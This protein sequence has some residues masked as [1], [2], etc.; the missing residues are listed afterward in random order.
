VKERRGGKKKAKAKQKKEMKKQLAEDPNYQPEET[1]RPKDELVGAIAK[2]NGMTA[3]EVLD[4]QD[5]KE[6]YNPKDP[7]GNDVNWVDFE[8]IMEH[9]G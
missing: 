3:E 5:H 7:F 1:W 4:I 8:I 9:F 6:D 2:L